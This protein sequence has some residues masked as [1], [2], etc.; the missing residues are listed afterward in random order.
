MA[1]CC[2]YFDLK[3]FTSSSTSC[4]ILSRSSGSPQTAG[5]PNL[6]LR[7]AELHQVMKCTTPRG[8]SRTFSS[9]HDRFRSFPLL[10]FTLQTCAIPMCCNTFLHRLSV[11]RPLMLFALRGGFAVYYSFITVD[12][13]DSGVHWIHEES[14]CVVGL[15]LSLRLLLFA[16]ELRFL[17]L[18][19]VCLC[20]L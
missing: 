17:W 16:R 4:T 8:S 2:C 11:R 12:D 15:S 6:P 3:P 19:T 14:F 9:M 5:Q 1:L 13:D 20:L 18:C 7:H 10:Y